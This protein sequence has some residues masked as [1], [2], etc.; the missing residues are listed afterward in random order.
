MVELP[1]W[2]HQPVDSVKARLPSRED[3]ERRLLATRNGRLALVGGIY[4]ALGAVYVGG[5]V[6][7]PALGEEG[8]VAYYA[9]SS[10]QKGALAYFLLAGIPMYF[11]GEKAIKMVYQP[12]ENLL[13]VLDP[14]GEVEETWVLGDEKLARLTVEGG[15]LAS[16]RTTEGRVWYCME[17]DADENVAQ[18]TWEGTVDSGQVW[19][20]KKNLFECLT[21]T[22]DRARKAD[23]YERNEPERIRKSTEKELA[24]I[25]DKMG[26]LDPM[27]QGDGYEEE[28]A[29]T[30]DMG[31]ISPEAVDATRR[32]EEETAK[33]KDKEEVLEDAGRS[34][35]SE[36]PIQKAKDRFG[37][38]EDE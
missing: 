7:Y 29:E 5:N 27:V 32:Q 13:R 10:T 24:D 16:R 23:E 15:P 11:A 6:P 34:N 12:D 19:T 33:G 18:A 17:Y 31:G 20:T 35:G 22:Q 21:E 38:S 2:V 26:E 4:L 3:V 28:L 9:L 36:E 30:L 14:E 37:G 1:T 8:V 25:V